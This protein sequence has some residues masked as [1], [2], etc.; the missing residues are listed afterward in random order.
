MILLAVLPR[1]TKINT[2]IDGVQCSQFQSSRTFLIKFRFHK[3]FSK[4]Y[5]GQVSTQS[6][7]K[8]CILFLFRLLQHTK[9]SYPIIRFISKF[10]YIVPSV[11]R[12]CGKYLNQQPKKCFL[13]CISFKIMSNVN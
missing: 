9:L 1:H 11:F 13:G 6:N 10:I 5:S 7:K 8:M 3:S 2:L 4:D 12:T